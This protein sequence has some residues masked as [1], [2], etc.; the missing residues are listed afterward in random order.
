[1]ALILTLGYI[2]FSYPINKKKKKKSFSLLK[3]KAG[4]GHWWLTP[5]ILATQ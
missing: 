2:L 4:A 1:M 5:V 3:T